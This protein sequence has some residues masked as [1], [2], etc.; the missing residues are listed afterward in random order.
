MVLVATVVKRHDVDQ[1]DVLGLRVKAVHGHLQ[2]R[3]H[4]SEKHK[5]TKGKIR[6]FSINFNTIQS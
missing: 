4:P 6:T 1:H 2:A 5:Q 3:E